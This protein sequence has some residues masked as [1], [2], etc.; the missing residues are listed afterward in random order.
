MQVKLLNEDKDTLARLAEIKSSRE[1]KTIIAP[2]K[3]LEILESRPYDSPYTFLKNYNKN[4]SLNKR[5][6]EIRLVLSSK[7][8]NDLDDDNDKMRK[9]ISRFDRLTDPN[10]IRLLYIIYKPDRIKK[11]EN[12]SDK[13]G[14]T[15]LNFI[16]D[17]VIS[18]IKHGNIDGVIIPNLVPNEKIDDRSRLLELK[19][20]FIKRF[21]EHYDHKYIQDLIGYI[22]KSSHRRI[23]VITQQYIKVGLEN[24]AI[25]LNGSNIISYRAE[26]EALNRSIKLAQKELNKEIIFTY[27][28][29]V[30]R[31][32][33]KDPS[34]PAKDI[35]CIAIGINI[36]SYYILSRRIPLP[37]PNEKIVYRLFNNNYYVYQ[38]VS[39][40]MLLN[41]GKKEG[42][43]INTRSSPKNIERA[44]NSL[45]QN[46]ELINNIH[47]TIQDKRL[48][49]YWL[50]KNA[51]ND[52]LRILTKIIDSVRNISILS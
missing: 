25:D 27:G 26:L 28:L 41:E 20:I 39:K 1:A 32:L 22:P 7:R 9:F 3:A 40:D 37:Q 33:G 43:L 30:N 29:N 46:T 11:I 35:L 16:S 51:I 36:Y 5:I 38:H 6:V 31:G 8:I 14:E 24:L 15:E 47:T 44:L 19:G 18:S 49:N 2:I 21:L 45:Y 13:E 50:G 48:K 12:S 23:G 42:F 52:D 10:D 4:R 34:L 17:F